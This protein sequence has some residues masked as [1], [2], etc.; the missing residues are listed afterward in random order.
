MQLELVWVLPTVLPLEAEKK[1]VQIDAE[2]AE[3]EE[4]K[5]K[6]KVVAFSS[7]TSQGGRNYRSEGTEVET[8]KSTLE[9]KVFLKRDAWQMTGIGMEED[10]SP[11]RYIMTSQSLKK[12]QENILMRGS[13]TRDLVLLSQLNC[14]HWDV[15]SHHP[16]PSAFAGMWPGFF[17]FCTTFALSHWRPS[18]SPGSFCRTSWTGLLW[19]FGPWTWSSALARA[20]TTTAS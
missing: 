13:K 20:T 19:S 1:T 10:W 4:D 18:T 15:P 6:V 2:K 7:E 14:C 12:R 11:Q 16:H 17:S 9:N 5:R 3:E 8:P